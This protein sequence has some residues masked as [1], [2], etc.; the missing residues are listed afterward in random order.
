MAE[1]DDI[2]LRDILDVVKA[3]GDS[4]RNLDCKLSTELSELK[5][6]V[7][8]S[9]Q[10]VKKL[11]TDTQHKWKFE[12]NKIQYLF[13]SELLE[14]VTQFSWAVSNSKFDYAKELADSVSEKIKKRNKLIKIADTSEGGWETVRQYESN[15][16]ASDSDDEN[17]I[18]KAEVRAIRKN[19]ERTKNKV[20]KPQSES[21]IHPAQPSSIPQVPMQPFLA[22]QYN[23]WINGHQAFRFE[24][25]NRSQRRGGSCYACGSLS[26]WRS[27]CPYN[28]KSS[29][30]SA[31]KTKPE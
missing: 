2:S 18:H 25:S 13:N 6:E 17:K 29:T 4:L 5:Q 12:G 26:H 11:K 24:H 15:P 20:K 7:H 9:S 21:R 3:Q 30:A 8:G 23:P 14:D 22:P 1:S 27:E 16:V 19:K 28:T 31:T 10:V